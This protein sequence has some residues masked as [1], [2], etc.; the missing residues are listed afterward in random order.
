MAWW[1]GD[2][3]IY[4]PLYRWWI[5][6]GFVKL[7]GGVRLAGSHGPNRVSGVLY[8]LLCL[9]QK[10]PQTERVASGVTTGEMFSQVLRPMF[11]LWA[12]C[13]LL[14]SATELGPQQWQESVIT[15]TTEGKVSGTMVLVYTSSSMMF[16]MRH[17][18]GPLAHA[19]S[20]VGML[21]VSS[22]LSGIGLYLLSTADSAVTV[23]GYATI[24]GL[25]IAYFWPTML[26]V[27]LSGFLRAVGC[28]WVSW[29]AWGTSP[30]PRCCRSWAISTISNRGPA[31]AKSV[32]RVAVTSEPANW[33]L[34]LA[35]IQ[36]S[37]K[38]N[39]E[40]VKTLPEA[41]KKLVAEAEA[42]VPRWHFDEFFPAHHSCGHFRIDCISDKLRGGY[43]PEE[44]C[45]PG[46]KRTN[47][48]PAACRDRWSDT[49]E[50]N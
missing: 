23:F 17:F 39:L 16:V 47:F 31:R 27:T 19:L 1:L 29:A 15:R 46:R 37:E 41:D 32:T 30:S 9:T 28:C 7:D 5:G 14:T 40:E 22:L 36:N 50:S 43:K 24:F 6:S 44:S 18:A 8:I 11:V 45:S 20:P 21:T 4:R 12:F 38:I 25:G 49:S 42:R 13:M 3:C 33:A 2:W 35:G 10:F 48:S 26:G 34:Q